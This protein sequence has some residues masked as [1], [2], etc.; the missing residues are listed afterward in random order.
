MYY[1]SRLGNS[2]LGHDRRRRSGSLSSLYILLAPPTG[3][4]GL[5]SQSPIWGRRTQVGRRDLRLRYEIA[6]SKPGFLA[7]RF[8]RASSIRPC[9]VQMLR[10]GL[11]FPGTPP[12]CHLVAWR[13]TASCSCSVSPAHLRGPGCSCS[14]QWIVGLHSRCW[15]F[16]SFYPQS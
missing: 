13:S 9:W 12:V 15:W 10:E 7:H 6:W 3:L 5:R 1:K 11:T 2:G 4:S 8:L 16:P 14:F